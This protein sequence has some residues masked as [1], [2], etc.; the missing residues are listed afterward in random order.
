[1]TNSE[2]GLGEHHIP[3]VLFTDLLK[4]GGLGLPHL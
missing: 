2:W 1:M 3:E 4:D